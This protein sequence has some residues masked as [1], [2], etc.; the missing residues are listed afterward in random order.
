MSATPSWEGLLR[1]P[2]PCNDD[3]FLAR[4]VSMFI[5]LGLGEGEDAVNV[6]TPEHA[7]LFALD[8]LSPGIADAV[9]DRTRFHYGGV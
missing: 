2:H 7:A 9:L 4:A 8:N 6:C 5:G 3:A 1:T